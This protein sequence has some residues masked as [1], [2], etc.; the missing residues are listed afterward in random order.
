MS[1]KLCWVY[2]AFSWTCLVEGVTW[3]CDTQRDNGLRL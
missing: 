1:Q 3:Q 2:F